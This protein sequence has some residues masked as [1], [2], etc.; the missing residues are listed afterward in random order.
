[1]A[2]EFGFVFLAGFERFGMFAARKLLG[3]IAAQ[4]GSV[5]YV[6]V[7]L[8]CRCSYF[9]NLLGLKLP[10][11]LT[12]RASR[13]RHVL[14][15][16][17]VFWLP[18][19][20]Y[21][22]TCL[23]PIVQESSCGPIIWHA[24]FAVWFTIPLFV[25]GAVIIS[26][27]SNPLV[28]F[29]FVVILVATAYFHDAVIPAVQPQRIGTIMLQALF[30]FFEDLSSLGWI[31]CLCHVIRIQNHVEKTGKKSCNKTESIS[32]PQR[33]AV[34]VG[35]GPS[36]VR[37]PAVGSLIDTYTEVVRFNS[38]STVKPEFTGMK[39]SYHFCNGR[40]RPNLDNV[41]TAAPLFYS[42]ITHACYL[43]MPRMEEALS[44][45]T[46]LMQNDAWFIPE[47]NILELI[48]EIGLPF[49]QI[50]SS[51]MI[52]IYAFLKKYDQVSLHG[53]DFFA[54]KNIHYF[55]ETLLQLLTSWLERFVTHNPEMEKEWVK[56]LV[57]E[58]KT[59]FLAEMP[60]CMLPPGDKSK[61]INSDDIRSASRQL[62]M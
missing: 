5:T 4:L 22:H 46:S 47:E 30:T 61:L 45:C 27:V 53:F 36:V 56:K 13:A 42:S 60:S 25:V 1:M 20:F 40:R 49:W 8:L 34:I 29:G 6:L 58:R 17:L 24:L 32:D 48:K 44:V 15:A 52:A 2:Q 33:C 23:L 18:F 31:W 12:L 35:N 62:A 37:E 28:H 57:R 38:F 54:G 59:L 10:L 26:A 3:R 14:A 55:E 43:F 9:C 16:I 39:T 50:P 21:C 11:G 19:S 41:M 7:I 51:G